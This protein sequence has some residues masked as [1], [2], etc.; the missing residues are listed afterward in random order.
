[1]TNFKTKKNTEKLVSII[2]NLLNE[3]NIAKNILSPIDKAVSSFTY[4][5]VIPLTNNSFISIISSFVSHI[6]ENG[7]P[8]RQTL[9]NRQTGAQAMYLLE[10]GYQ[11]TYGKG[12]EA[13]YGTIMHSDLYDIDD[14]LSHLAEIIKGEARTNYINWIFNRHLHHVEWN[15]K[16]DIVEH[17]QKQWKEFLGENIIKL[18]L[19][20]KASNLPNL[21]TLIL[22]SMGEIEKI[23]NNE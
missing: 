8:I 22:E 5:K 16:C 4:P 23:F 6:Y 21:F 11:N 14:L 1:M 15:I 13:A 3:Y 19:A 9:N 18:P 10:S 12:Y 7:M 2:F 17:L 20:E